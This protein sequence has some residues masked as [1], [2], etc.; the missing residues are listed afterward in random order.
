M[1]WRPMALTMPLAGLADA[2]GGG[3]GHWLEGEALY[4]DAAEAV[5][6]DEVGEL[7]AVAEGAAGSNDRV[8]E[9]NGTDADAEVNPRGRGSVGRGALTASGEL[10]GQV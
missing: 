1:F 10:T 8:L 3:S 6:V 4:D 5:Q 2:G 9:S 7:D